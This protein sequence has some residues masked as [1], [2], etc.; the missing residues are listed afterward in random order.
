MLLPVDYRQIM[1]HP[2]KYLGITETN[3][4][5]TKTRR[6]GIL[7]LERIN[8]LTEKITILSKK[9][10]PLLAVYN[11]AQSSHKNVQRHFE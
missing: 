8:N 11:R 10:V 4:I 7:S 9:P 1:S 5:R 3:K 6:N 2:L